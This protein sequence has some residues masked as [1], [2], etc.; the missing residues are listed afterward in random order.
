MRGKDKEVIVDRVSVHTMGLLI[1]CVPRVCRVCVSVCRGRERHRIPYSA[2][3]YGTVGR[4]IWGRGQG[5][6]TNFV[7][8]H[9]KRDP[10]RNER[11][12]PKGC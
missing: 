5:A 11:K 8:Q 12:G 7:L 6:V 2:L 10:R 4:G 9:D 3:E 1:A